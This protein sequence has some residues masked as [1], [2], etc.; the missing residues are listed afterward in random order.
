M[1]SFEELLER[2]RKGFPLPEAILSLDAEAQMCDADDL[3]EALRTRLHVLRETVD[4]A[5][6]GHWQPKLIA[7]DKDKYPA[8]RGKALSGQLVWRAS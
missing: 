6:A 3:R 1:R 2:T 7:D 4:A 5:L 8:R